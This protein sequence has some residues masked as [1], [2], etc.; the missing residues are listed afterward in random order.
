M[1]KW[2]QSTADF[3][4]PIFRPNQASCLQSSD[5][6]LNPLFLKKRVIWGVNT[7][8]LGPRKAALS[9]G[10]TTHGYTGFSRHPELVL[11]GG[12]RG[13]SFLNFKD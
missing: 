8:A 6:A 3:L 10:I 2:Q 11:A 7:C 5:S 13:V 4:F 1:L 9:G 12:E